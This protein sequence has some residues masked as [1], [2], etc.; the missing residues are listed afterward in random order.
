MKRDPTDIAPDIDAYLRLLEKVPWFQN[1]GKPDPRDNEI[2]R[3]HSWEE[4][5]GP[6]RGYGD[7]FGRWQ[8]VV[9]EQLEASV[10]PAR[11]KQL[12]A[13][14]KRIDRL[15][16][17]RAAANVPLYDPERDPW[18]GPTA[19]VWCAAYT[20]CLIG[21]HIALNRRLPE[22]LAHEWEWYLAGHWPCDYAEEPPGYWDETTV[23][24]PSG[25]LLVY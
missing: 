24:L 9:Q 8:S 12:K 22:R 4:W 15:V 17:E 10:P 19:C 20:A 6:E 18:Y 21:W 23:D 2:T 13:H 7:W 5:P 11:R 1:L 3:I 14:W 25:R 16:S